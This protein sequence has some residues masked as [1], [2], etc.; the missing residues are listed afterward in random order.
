MLAQIIDDRLGLLAGIHRGFQ[1]IGLDSGRFER[2]DLGL[3]AVAAGGVAGLL[4]VHDDAALHAHR[5]EALGGQRAGGLLVRAG[6]E[7]EEVV[8]IAHLRPRRRRRRAAERDARLFGAGRDVGVGRVLSEFAQRD[9]V[10]FRRD[11]FLDLLHLIRDRQRIRV[12]VGHFDAEVLAGLFGAA[13]EIAVE[14]SRRRAA[15]EIDRDVVVSHR[16]AARCAERNDGAAKDREAFG[17]LN[18]EFG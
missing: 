1:E 6:A 5:D 2:R 17:G 16:D 3:G 11:R 12:D 13:R 18:A 7:Q 9:A 14:S 8:G 10:G 4:V 15:D